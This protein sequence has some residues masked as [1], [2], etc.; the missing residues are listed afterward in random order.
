MTF[1]KIPALHVHP[2]YLVAGPLKR[3]FVILSDGKSRLDIL[4]GAGAYAACGIALW[5]QPV[6]LT[7]RVGE[8]YPHEWLEDLNKHQIDTRGVKILP[9]IMDLRLFTGYNAAGEHETSNPVRYFARHTIPF[10]SIL[11]NYTPPQDTKL[12]IEEIQITSPRSNDIPK[13]FLDATAAHICAVDYLTQSLLQPVLRSGEVKTITI[14][15]H[16]SYMQPEYFNKLAAIVSGLTAFLVKEDDLRLFFRNRTNDLVEMAAAVA[17]LGCEMVIIHLSDGNKML[18]ELTTR[19]KWLIPMY[20]SARI[21][22][23]SAQASFGGGLLA[24][25][26]LSFDPLQALKYG[27]ITESIAAEGLHPLNMFDSLPG[28]AKARINALDE[29]V[30]PI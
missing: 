17:N 4:G 29:M 8:D 14:D 13:D 1:G 25:Y 27:I 3:E 18:Y 7:C 24:G 26:R 2:K 15:A 6:G 10:P 12:G 23:H 21:N 28:L 5:D 9:Q 20:P 19:K 16:T 11:L 30:R 22:Y